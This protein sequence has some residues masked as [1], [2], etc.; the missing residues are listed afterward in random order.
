MFPPKFKKIGLKLFGNQNP[1]RSFSQLWP[2]PKGSSHTKD[3]VSLR[4]LAST[5]YGF[6]AFLDQKFFV[7]SFFWWEFL[8]GLE[9]ETTNKEANELAKNRDGGYHVARCR[10]SWLVRFFY[11]LFLWE[12]KSQPVLQLLASWKTCYSLNSSEFNTLFKRRYQNKSKSPGSR[13][14]RR[15]KPFC[16]TWYV[17]SVGFSRTPNNGTPLWE[18]SHIIPIPLP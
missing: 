14:R 1:G 15:P 17:R 12:A 13:P 6:L 4:E 5:Y 7:E 11:V 2:F 16:C 8:V 10:G 9:N 3:V 18:V